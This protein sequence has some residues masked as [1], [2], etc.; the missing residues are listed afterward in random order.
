MKSQTKKKALLGHFLLELILVFGDVKDFLPVIIPA[1]GADVMGS[2]HCAAFG[3]GNDAVDF[4]FE[5]RTTKSFRS[6]A[7]TSLWDSHFLMLL[8][9]GLNYRQDGQGVKANFET[10]SKIF[11]INPMMSHH[12]IEWF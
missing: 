2:N 5:V 12:Y 3:A 9:T 4:E 6:F 8:S 11:R 7:S 10:M 1:L